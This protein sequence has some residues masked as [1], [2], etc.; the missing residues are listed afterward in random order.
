M[1]M[2]T[3]WV[4]EVYPKSN[5][6]MMV[7]ARKLCQGILW[8][9]AGWGRGLAVRS[10]TTEP[11]Q[12]S[13]AAGAWGA[14]ALVSADKGCHYHVPQRGCHVNQTVCFVSNVTSDWWMRHF[15]C[16]GRTLYT[17]QLESHW[18]AQPLPSPLPPALCSQSDR[19]GS[20]CEEL[21]KPVPWSGEGRW[22]WTSDSCSLRE[23]PG[24]HRIIEMSF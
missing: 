11:G 4:I 24:K 8:A 12:G 14:R 16:P 6:K 21:S 9:L 7:C 17:N 15:G 5:I 19:T 10:P 2:N 18:Q 3:R 23:T 1:S 13:L 20:D 22:C